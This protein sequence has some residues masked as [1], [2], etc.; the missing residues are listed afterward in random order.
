MIAGCIA[1]AAGSG[2]GGDSADLAPARLLHAPAVGRLNPE[3]LRALSMDCEKYPVHGT[4]RG[5]YEAAY[6]DAAMA[7]WSDSPLQMVPVPAQTV[8][9]PPETV[10]IPPK[11]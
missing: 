4:F 10:P 1:L 2:C 11:P 3:Q 8:P 5:R 6:C 7:A 9:A